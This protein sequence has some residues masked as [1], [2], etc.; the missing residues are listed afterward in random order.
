MNDMLQKF[1]DSL[2]SLLHNIISSI[3][4]VLMYTL[5]FIM[6]LIFAKYFSILIRKILEK[7]KIDNLTDELQSIDLFK[8]FNLKIS[9]FISRIIYWIIILIFGIAATEALDLTMFSKGISSILAYIPQLLSAIV[10]FFAGVFVANLLRKVIDS[11]FSSMGIAAGRIIANFVFYFLVIIIAITALNQTGL[12]T[13][14]ITKNI[15]NALLAVFLAFAISYG[16]ASKDIL[17]NLL[18]SFYSRN[19]FKV[20]QTIRLGDVEGKIIDIDSTSVILENEG[21][22]IVLPLSKLLNSTVEIL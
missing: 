10:F 9:D 6:V 7:L 11:A 1:T 14:V 4:T 16:F 12:N 5:I 8:N 13:E 17:A 22:K 20:G 18:S 21:R 15:S 2:Q 3:P 19:K